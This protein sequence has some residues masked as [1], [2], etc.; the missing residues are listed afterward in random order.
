[1]VNFKLLF[2]FKLRKKNEPETIKD[3]N[4]QLALCFSINND[5]SDIAFL[6]ELTLFLKL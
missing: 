5:G 6:L 4:G 2:F 1:M 3:L